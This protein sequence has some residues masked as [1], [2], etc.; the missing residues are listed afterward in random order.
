MN[1]TQDPTNTSDFFRG[2]ADAWF[3]IYGM[4]KFT[5]VQEA[6]GIR[7]SAD[8]LVDIYQNQ[9]RAE[10]VTYS[11]ELVLQ[12]GSVLG[13]ALKKLFT[14][15]WHYSAQQERWVVF[16]TFPMGSEIELNIFNKLEK[17]FE[18]GME[19]SIE[20]FYDGIK[21]LYLEEARTFE[22]AYGQ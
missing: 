21:N 20:Y 7:Q 3:E 5:D 6:I 4:P 10:D 14:G 17:R 22:E 2:K 19:D 15:E 9:L 16:A 13:E 11:E 8:S 1:P 18:N 12:F